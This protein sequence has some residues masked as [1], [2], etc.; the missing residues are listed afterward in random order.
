M[1]TKGKILTSEEMK[2]MKVQPTSGS[3][4][5]AEDPCF[6]VYKCSNGNIVGCAADHKDDKCMLVVRDQKEV[7]GVRCGNKPMIPCNAQGSGSGSGF[8]TNLTP[9]PEGGLL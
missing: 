9:D 3:G 6:L 7:I 4:S 1:K 8:G 5:G 2:E